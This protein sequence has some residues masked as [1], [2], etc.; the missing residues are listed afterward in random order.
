VKAL[1]IAGLFSAALWAQEF[2]RSFSG[3]V[4]DA[5]GAPIAK[6]KIAAT[7]TRTGAKSETVPRIPALIP[8]PSWRLV[9]I[10][11]P[12]RRRGSRHSCAP[13]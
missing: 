13:G 9:N 11:L 4:T 10:K 12:Q 5:Q 2:R 3:S 7:E 1:V 6:A 8:S